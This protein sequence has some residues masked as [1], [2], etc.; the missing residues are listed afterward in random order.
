M[1]THCGQ[2]GIAF[3][4]RLDLA[5]VGVEKTLSLRGEC[6]Q[7]EMGLSTFVLVSLDDG[8][9]RFAVHT[10]STSDA[11]KRAAAVPLAND[12]GSLGLAHVRASSEMRSRESVATEVASRQ[13]RSKRGARSSRSLGVSPARP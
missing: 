11:A 6:R 9:H 10:Q 8:G 12:L 7:V 4:K 3:Q 2:I 5:D 1:Q 13:S